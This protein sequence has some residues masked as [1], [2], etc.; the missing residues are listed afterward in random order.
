MSTKEISK[1]TALDFLKKSCKE[2]GSFSLRFDDLDDTMICLSS[3]I[4]DLLAT[5]VNKKITI[6][7]AFSIVASMLISIKKYEKEKNKE[8]NKN[9]G[10]FENTLRNE[11]T[12][13]TQD[14]FF[15][16][17]FF[18]NQNGT[19]ELNF[20]N[21]LHCLHMHSELMNKIFNAINEICNICIPEHNAKLTKR[22]SEEIMKSLLDSKASES[23][24]MKLYENKEIHIKH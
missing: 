7:D 22:C 10:S 2:D 17:R 12:N 5:M 9:P 20:P 21:L 23:N 14:L 4:K 8:N 6:E 3:C 15:K 11:M 13:E 24:L 1:K 18:E 16:L 19:F